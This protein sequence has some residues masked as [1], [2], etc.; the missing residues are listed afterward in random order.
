MR[1]TGPTR[2]VR[3]KGRPAAARLRAGAEGGDPGM[4][5]PPDRLVEA[6]LAAVER[7]VVGE[8]D[9]VEAGLLQGGHGFLGDP[10]SR[11]SSS[12]RAAPDPRRRRAAPRGCRPRGPP[13]RSA[14]AAG[15]ASSHGRAAPAAG[16]AARPG[17][18]ACRTSPKPRS[19]SSRTVTSDDA[20]AAPPDR[21]G[22]QRQAT[23][24]PDR[25]DRPCP[26]DPGR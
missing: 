22:S 7:V 9:G 4:A 6:G 5:Q 19:P 15:A 1:S 14:R 8:R 16:A 25:Q 24:T 3:T 13:S 23:P 21:G 20:A 17:A 26:A 10:T 18:S 11:D 2:S 12:G